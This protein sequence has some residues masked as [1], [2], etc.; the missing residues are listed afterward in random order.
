[1]DVHPCLGELGDHSN[2]GAVFTDDGSYHVTW[3]ED[4]VE[5]EGG[6]SEGKKRGRS[7]V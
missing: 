1:M 2:R 5:G 3:N 6:K 4:T 7:K